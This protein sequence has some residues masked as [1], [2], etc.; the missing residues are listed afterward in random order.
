MRRCERVLHRA[1]EQRERL[2]KVPAAHVHPLVAHAPCDV[3]GVDGVDVVDRLGLRMI[4]GRD[5]V[6]G[7][8]ADVSGP[9]RHR[10]HQV[11]LQGQAIPVPAG[12]LDDRFHAPVQQ[13][14]RRGK[15]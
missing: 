2:V 11:G 9:E 5:V 12:E 7:H 1:D 13:E 6:A 10:A 8:Q 15:G 3:D 14:V 4:S